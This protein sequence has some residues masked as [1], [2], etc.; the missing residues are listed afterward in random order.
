MPNE[1]VWKIH[2]VRCM[3]KLIHNLIS[4]GQLDDEE[5]NLTFNS[6]GWK[7]TKG[8]MV[9]TQGVK[10]EDSTLIIVSEIHNSY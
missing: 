7:V 1:S 9:V 6:G 10:L 2:K 5:H 8:A 4:V 3:P